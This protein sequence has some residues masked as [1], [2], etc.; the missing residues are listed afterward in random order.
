MKFNNRNIQIG[1]NVEIGKNVKI[2]DNTIIYDNVI[3]HD[4]SIICD[5]CVIGEPL[6]DYYHNQ[7]YTQP[8][9]IIGRMS[10]IRSH[11]IIYAGGEFGNN[12]TTGHRVTIREYTKIGY[13]TSIGSYCDLQGKCEIGNYNRFHSYVNIGQKSK[14]GDYVFIYPFVVLTNDPTPPSNTLEGVTIGDFSQIAAAAV[15]LPATSIGKHC[16]ISANSVVGGEFA[17]NSFIGGAPAKRICDLNKAPLIN[18]ETAKRHYPWPYNFDRGM[19][20]QDIGFAKWKN[21]Q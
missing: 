3:I 19:P 9:T 14:T 20:W 6:V 16:L 7:D 8:K 12:F 18:R 10:L 2:G 13:H 15:L 5:N 17:N 4:D 1:E 21:K 11:C